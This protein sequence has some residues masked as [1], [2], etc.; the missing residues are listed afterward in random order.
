MQVKHESRTS[1]DPMTQIR[2]PQAPLAG[3]SRHKRVPQPL[4][5]IGTINTRIGE[6]VL[7]NILVD[8][9][10]HEHRLPMSED[11]ASLTSGC[12]IHST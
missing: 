7:L 5:E 11:Y 9:D 8:R 10:W 3:T 6:K 1:A 2:L 12:L 4:R